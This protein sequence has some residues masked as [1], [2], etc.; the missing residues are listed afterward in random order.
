M[1][2]YCSPPPYNQQTYTHDIFDYTFMKCRLEET[3][4]RL[5]IGQTVRVY[6][7]DTYKDV[8]VLYYI[9]LNGADGLTLAFLWRA[10][11]DYVYLYVLENYA[12]DYIYIGNH[13]TMG[14]HVKNN[15]FDMHY[16][17]YATNTGARSSQYYDIQDQIE[18]LDIVKGKVCTNPYMQKCKVFKN[19]IDKLYETVLPQTV[20]TGYSFNSL[21]IPQNFSG[22]TFPL[23]KWGGKKKQQ[24][25]GDANITT[26]YDQAHETIKG[27][28]FYKTMIANSVDNEIACHAIRGNVGMITIFITENA[29]VEQDNKLAL[30]CS[31]NPTNPN[32]NNGN[33]SNK[34]IIP[35][36]YPCVFGNEPKF[37]TLEDMLTYINAKEETDANLIKGIAF[38][39][40]LN[41]TD[42][43]PCVL[44]QN[45]LSSK[46]CVG[47][48]Q[49]SCR[50]VY[51]INNTPMQAPLPIATSVYG[52]RKNKQSTKEKIIAKTTTSKK[53]T[54]DSKPQTTKTTKK[55]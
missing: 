41:A 47:D 29:S 49:Q 26:L 52:G 6:K 24:K 54:K 1:S 4:Q 35:Y 19:V 25:G 42:F 10:T 36:S 48:G 30:S 5:P 45:E 8:K 21:Y 23:N 32:L 27:T 37:I 15:K 20:Y 22:Q 51:S 38:Q 46:I 13:F 3:L 17:S 40:V 31:V 18:T 2:Q 12:Q 28:T 50:K 33:V 7:N 53:T 14:Y 55:V 16:T 43:N 34:H 39:A 9:P 44:K 11:N